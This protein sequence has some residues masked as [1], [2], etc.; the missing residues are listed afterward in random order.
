MKDFKQSTGKDLWFTLLTVIQTY[1][2]SD[3]MSLN[4]KASAIYEV[5][6]FETASHVFHSMIRTENKS[7]PLS[8]VEDGMF[9]LGW[10][11]TEE[12]DEKSMPWSFLI[13]DLAFAVNEE[14]K[15][16]RGKLKKKADT[17]EQ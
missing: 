16:L 11:Q 3:K 15:D 9:R 13:V 2:D 7:I 17:L 8:E 4:D 5:C 1:I 12:H 6:D 10:L 14:F